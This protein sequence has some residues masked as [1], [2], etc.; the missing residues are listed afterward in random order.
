[1]TLLASTLLPYLFRVKS[2][3]TV[4]TCTDWLLIQLAWYNLKECRVTECSYR[5]CS[6]HIQS[7][8]HCITIIYNIFHYLNHSQL[9]CSSQWAPKESVLS[10]CLAEITESLAEI[11]DSKFNIDWQCVNLCFYTM[12]CHNYNY[13]TIMNDI[14]R[15]MT[16]S[17]W[18]IH[19][20]SSCTHAHN[21]FSQKGVYALTYTCHLHAPMHTI[22]FPKRECMLC[23]TL[24]VFTMH[25]NYYRFPKWSACFNTHALAVFT[26][27]LVAYIAHFIFLHCCDNRIMYIYNYVYK[28]KDGTRVQSSEYI[29]T[30]SN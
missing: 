2:I 4:N 5:M 30:R 9:E 21:R 25:T 26:T 22:D 3:T 20:P 12:H 14:Y 15:R 23:H 6:M 27:L 10:S 7:Y 13:Y 18:H 19:L 11:T 16:I 17:C 24:A 1:M 8:L 28:I 29:D